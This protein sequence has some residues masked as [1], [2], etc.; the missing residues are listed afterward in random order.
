MDELVVYKDGQIVVSKNIIQSLK[1]F[2]KMKIQLEM[3]EKRLRE[4]LLEAMEKYGIYNWQSDDGSVKA[5]YKS[6][7][8]RKIIDSARLKKELPDIAEEYSKESETKSSVAL[9][10]EV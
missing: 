3:D 5:I 8:T 9:T 6:G 1:D 10:I 7:S 4:S 2:E